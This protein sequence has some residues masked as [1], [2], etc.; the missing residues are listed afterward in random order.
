M[1]QN[2][3][4][5]RNYLITKFNFSEKHLSYWWADDIYAINYILQGAIKIKDEQIISFC[6]N[7]VEKIININRHNY[8]FK[9]LLLHTLCLTSNLFNKYNE[10]VKGLAQKITSNQYNNGSWIEGHSLRIPHPSVLNPNKENIV[11]KEGNRGT[12]IIVKDYNRVFTTVSCLSALKIY[13]K[14]I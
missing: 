6:E 11:W 13:E 14:R 12:N 8:F 5:L 9:G 7:F 4:E 2:F 3:K 10:I 1:N